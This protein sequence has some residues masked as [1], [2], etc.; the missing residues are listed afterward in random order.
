MYLE[1]DLLKSIDS[2]GYGVC[3]SHDLQSA[4]RRS[5]RDGGVVGSPASLRT[6]GTDSSLGL[7]CW[8]PGVSRIGGG[9][10]SLFHPAASEFNIPLVFVLV[11][12]S[13]VWMIHTNT[14]EGHLFCSFTNF[15]SFFQLVMFPFQINLI[16]YDTAPSQSSSTNLNTNVS[17]KSLPRTRVSSVIWT[18][19]GPIVGTLN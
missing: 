4:K 12:H 11:K 15:L 17:Q 5:R 7:K 14:D 13:V 2:Q 16:G 10:A 1:R 19:S 9:C 6:E 3:L 8:E 18:S